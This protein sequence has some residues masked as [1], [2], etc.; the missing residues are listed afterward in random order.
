MLEKIWEYSEA[1]HNLFI[2]F[3]RAYDA[4]RREVL[5]N[6]LPEFGILMKLVRLR[7]KHVSE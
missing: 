1:V 2:E 4:V 7:N 3:Q 5:R 6:I